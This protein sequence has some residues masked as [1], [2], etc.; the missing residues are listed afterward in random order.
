MRTGTNIVDTGLKE[1]F[2]FKIIGKQGQVVS[3]FKTIGLRRL[4]GMAFTTAAV[5]YAAVEGMSALYDV[6]QDERAAMRR[7]VAD[8]SKNSTLVPLKDK[9]GKLKYVDFSHSNAYDTLTRPIQTVINRVQ[10]GEQDK[11]GIM[12]DFILGLA[13]STKE[14][15]LPFVSESIWT[16]ALADVTVRR[17]MSP[18]G[19]KIWNDEDSM[20]RRIQK[21]IAHLAMAQAPLNWKQ[22]ERLNLSMKPVDDLGRFDE[23]GNEY[24]FGNE[25]AGI[26]GFRAVDVDPEKGLKYKIADYKKGSRNSKAL[27]TTEVL[28]GGVTTP[29]DIID[30]YINANRALFLNQKAM[31][32]DIKAAKTLGMKEQDLTQQVVQG[33]GRKGYGKLNAGIFTPMSISK[34][35]VQGFQRI[36]DELGI[37]NPLLDSMNAIANIRSQLF[38]VGLDEEAGIPDIENPFDTPIIPDLVG[39]VTNTTQLPPLPNP[40]LATGTQFGGNVLTGV[41]EADRFAALFPG[42]ELG[43]LAANKKQPTRTI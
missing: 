5:P 32:E 30:A 21:A 40:N 8:W 13:E 19:F 37:R 35:V 12:N 33:I 9:E 34:N 31:Y 25:A 22:L 17:G 42:D 29:K 7:Y 2:D 18:E 24:E 38:N 27:F 28:K 23:R 36:A 1:I 3:P 26:V 39:A 6:T 11:D 43:K 15:A 14:L 10:A 20:G 4:G 41:N 16:E